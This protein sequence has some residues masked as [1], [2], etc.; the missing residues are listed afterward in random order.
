[1]QKLLTTATINKADLC[2]ELEGLGANL[3]I[4]TCAYLFGFSHARM[5][6]TIQDALLFYKKIREILGNDFITYF[7]YANTLGLGCW[8]RDL[9]VEIAI[10]DLNFTKKQKDAFFRECEELEVSYTNLEEESW[11]F[12]FE[13][14]DKM[15]SSENRQIGFECLKI[16]K[17]PVRH[18]N[19]RNEWVKS[20][21]LSLN[22]PQSL[23][24][25]SD[26]Y[27]GEGFANLILKIENNNGA[28]FSILFLANEAQSL[29]FFKQH[30][31]RG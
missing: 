8:F 25:T 3:G 9:I 20:S 19:M 18:E 1:M 15:K 6:K 31:I 23:V 24:C 16:L 17:D 26:L 28:L 30:K 11:S 29:N 13:E 2:N 22:D 27:Y 4:M 7:D 5:I 21:L 10:H 12:F 14:I